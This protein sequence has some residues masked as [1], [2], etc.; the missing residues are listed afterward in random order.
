MKLQTDVKQNGRDAVVIKKLKYRG[1]ER[2]RE[3][4]M[5]RERKR[6]KE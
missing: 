2:V 3:R 5:N 1:R 4:K 6:E